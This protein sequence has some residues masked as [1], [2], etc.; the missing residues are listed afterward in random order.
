MY[1]SSYTKSCFNHGKTPLHFKLAYNLQASRI[2]DSTVTG[3]HTSL[4]EYM[5][6]CE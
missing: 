4:K 5:T 2:N 3:P 6:A 1:F